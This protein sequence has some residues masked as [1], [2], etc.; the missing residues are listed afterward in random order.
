MINKLVC[1]AQNPPATVTISPAGP[2]GVGL[3]A[4]ATRDFANDTNGPF[5]MES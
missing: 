4:P 3:S 5:V 1:E 2:T